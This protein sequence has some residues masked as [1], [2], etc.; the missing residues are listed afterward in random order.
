MIS[1]KAAIEMSVGTIVT[2]VLLM[3]TLILG[4]V[5]VRTIFS[6]SIENINSID[7]AVKSEIN[8]LFAEDD[9]RTVVIYPPTREISIKQG[10]E[11]G[12]GFSIRNTNKGNTGS[13]SFSYSVA[14][15]EASCGLTAAQAEELI[16]LGKTG[17]YQIASGNS[18][19]N[20]VLVKFSI[21]DSVPLCDIRY[22]ITIE[23]GGEVYGNTVTVDLKILSK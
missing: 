11:G 21:S 18:L 19:D 17:T 10:A 1:K 3:T 6:G 15:A 23:N 4:L 13:N 9:A 20:P 16:I 12:F 5:M 14:F 22:G 8:K 2:I 7:Q